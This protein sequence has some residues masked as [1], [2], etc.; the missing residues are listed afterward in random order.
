MIPERPQ[1]QGIEKPAD[2][3]EKENL[4]ALENLTEPGGTLPYGYDSAFG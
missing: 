4:R 2:F 1:P 3:D